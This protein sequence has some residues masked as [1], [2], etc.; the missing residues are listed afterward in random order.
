V[1]QFI[2]MA[3]YRHF[4]LSPAADFVELHP[5]GGALGLR[6]NRYDCLPQLIGQLHLLLKNV[7]DL[8]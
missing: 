4:G 3:F 6:L 8:H 2:R 7:S 1:K 5:G